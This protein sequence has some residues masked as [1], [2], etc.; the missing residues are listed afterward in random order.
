MSQRSA[1]VLLYRRRDYGIEVLL[2]H[3]GGPY[4]ARKDNGAW[5]IPKGLIETG[6]DPQAVA[7]REFEEET[8]APLQG[9]LAPLGAF[10][11]SR[12]KTIEVWATEGDF[13]PATLRSNTFSIEWPPRSGRLQDF[14]EVDRAQWFTPQVAFDKILKGQR[15]V[16]EALLQRLAVGR[17]HDGT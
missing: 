3:P 6:E 10:A 7:L 1:G 11:Q 9:E 12:A 8:G 14:P 15:P 13:D 2:V 16:I 17:P 5:S 4:W